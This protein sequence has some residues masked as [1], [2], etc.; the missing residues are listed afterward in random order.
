[1]ARR[2]ESRLVLIGT[3]IEHTTKDDQTK[4]DRLMK[5][6]DDFLT[7]DKDRA[8]FGLQPKETTK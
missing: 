1:M 7:R 3:C 8:V 5:G 2:H 4:R 6:L